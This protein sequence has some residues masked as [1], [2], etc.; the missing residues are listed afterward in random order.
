EAVCTPSTRSAISSA[1]RVTATAART[2]PR[3]TTQLG[4]RPR[5]R[6][7]AP[8]SSGGFPSTARG[9]APFTPPPTTS[10]SATRADA[11]AALVAAEA[12]AKDEH[13][14][15]EPGERGRQ[16]DAGE[17]GPRTAHHLDR[18]EA[19]EAGGEEPVEKPR[20]APGGT[21]A[22]GGT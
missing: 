3:L 17:R 13:R 10:R 9:V 18:Q 6:P 11:L 8:P 12:A 21:G 5:C 7:R 19:D 14:E 15:R 20:D 1:P 4:R 16:H 2:S 22:R